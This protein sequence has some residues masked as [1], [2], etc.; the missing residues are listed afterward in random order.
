M[1]SAGEPER[2]P[3]DVPESVLEFLQKDY[4]LKITYLS[5][6]FSRM[7]TRFNFFI[8]LETALI[9]GFFG[10]F[11]DTNRVSGIMPAVAG[12]GIVLS[13]CWYVFGA[14]DRY[15]V[16]VHRSHLQDAGARIAGQLG[17]TERLGFDYVHVGDQST[18]VKQHIYQWRSQ[19]FSTTKLAAWFP[20]LVLLGWVIL[21]V[22]ARRILVAIRAS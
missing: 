5:D 18:R 6:H 2:G 10:L 17:L 19:R 9:A 4:E 8:V 3:L 20:L 22:F 14:Q 15:L 16:E 13:A 1:G 11:K 7:W 21:P 12:I